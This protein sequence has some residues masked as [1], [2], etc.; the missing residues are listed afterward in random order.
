MGT[1]VNVVA[2]IVGSIIGSLIKSKY[3][4]KHVESL[5]QA[6]SL[7]V[8]VIALNGIITNTVYFDDTG[9]HSRYELL[10]VLS[11]VIG[12]IIGEL[13]RIDDHI[14]NLSLR[15]EKRFQMQGFAKA[16]ITSSLIFSV[17]ALSVVGALNDGLLHDPSLL[18]VK[19]ALD[20]ITSIIIAS[21]LGMGVIFSSIVVLVYQGG[22]TLLAGVLSPYLQ[23]EL[24]MQICAVGYVLVLSIAMNIL[25]VTKIKTANF[26]PALLIPVI[27]Y[28]LKLLF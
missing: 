13:L 16:F 3:I 4:D 24:L 17:G 26:L 21:T 12:V 23:G 9:L 11:L 7:A 25:K 8:I 18:Y 15:V 28:L 1:I 5:H 14:N 27:W 20:G 22:I 19:S 10:I 6:L 2:I